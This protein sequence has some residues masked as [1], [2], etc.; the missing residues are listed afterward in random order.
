M[1]WLLY[2]LFTAVLVLAAFLTTELADVL[3]F[4]ET[5]RQQEEI[6]EDEIA[7]RD[8]EFRPSFYDELKIER[9]WRQRRG[10]RRV[11][12][13]NETKARAASK[14]RRGERS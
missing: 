9:E 1:K 12:R 11:I 3:K 6:P 4:R 14:S 2:S 7:D 13:E 5:A 8:R 10:E